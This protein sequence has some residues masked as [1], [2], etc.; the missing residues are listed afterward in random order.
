MELVIIPVCCITWQKLVRKGRSSACLQKCKASMMEE[1]CNDSGYI[2]RKDRKLLLPR[3]QLGDMLDADGRWNSA[4]MDGLKL[5]GK[6]SVSAYLIN[7]ERIFIKISCDKLSIHG[8]ETWPVEK[9]R[10]VKFDLTEVSM[11]RWTCEL[12]L[13]ERKNAEIRELL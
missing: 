5:H 10:E 7:W 8:S 6:S 2:T 9:E 11:L 3:C 1:K 13:K 4:V 12:K